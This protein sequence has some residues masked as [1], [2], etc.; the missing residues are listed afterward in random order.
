[1]SQ[2]LKLRP[3]QPFVQVEPVVHEKMALMAVS[4]P[5]IHAA[6]LEERHKYESGE[7]TLWRN[8]IYQVQKDTN[9]HVHPNWP[10]LIALSIKRIDR[11]WI[12]DW[13]D[14]QEIKNL[15]VGPDHEA[16]ELYPAEKRVVDTSNQYHLWVL[17]ESRLR[18]PFGW[19][20]GARQ[21]PEEAE[22]FGAKQR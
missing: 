6:L 14:L 11:E 18:F 9:P 20:K 15:L 13:R 3:M 22:M 5:V 12:H 21:T 10:R 4:N 1:M 2:P 16:I 7:L 8:D 17:A 19:D